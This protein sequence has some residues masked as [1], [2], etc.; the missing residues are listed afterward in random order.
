MQSHV[1]SNQPLHYR[2]TVRMATFYNCYCLCRKRGHAHDS[3]ALTKRNYPFISFEDNDKKKG[4]KKCL[5][6]RSSAAFSSGHFD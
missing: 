2:N 1:P 6:A 4:Y 3:L 5:K